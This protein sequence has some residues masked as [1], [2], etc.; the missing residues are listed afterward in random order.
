MRKRLQYILLALL[1]VLGVFP[2]NASGTAAD[3]VD[4]DAYV[5]ELTRLVQDT[6]SDYFLS[7]IEFRLDNTTMTVNGGV[8]EIDPGRDAAPYINEEGEPMLP[9]RAVSEALGLDVSFD[10]ATTDVN[11]SG[12]GIEI[13]LRSGDRTMRVNGRRVHMSS[14]PASRNG[15]TYLPARAVSESLL[16]DVDFIPEGKRVVLTKP[17]QTGRLIV[18]TNGASP[19][20]AY[21][22]DG[23]TTTLR[24]PDNTFIM[25]FETELDAKDA[26][27]KL[28]SVSVFAEPDVIVGIDAAYRSWGVAYI[29]A[30]KYLEYLTPVSKP[31]ITVAVLDT[32]VDSSHPFLAGRLTNGWNFINGSGNP[33]DGNGHGTHVAGTVAEL[34]L[35]NVTIIPVKVLSDQG[36]GSTSLVD[37]GIRYAADR[38]AAVINMSLGGA[39]TSQST[40]NAVQY[41]NGRNAVVVASAGNDGANAAGYTPANIPEVITVTA[42][43]SR[44]GRAYF[45]NFGNVIDVA[46]PG[47]SIISSIPGGR[48][49]AYDGTS[50]AAPHVSG[51]VALLK[52]DPRYADFNPSA[53]KTVLHGLTDD[54]GAPGFDIYFGHGIINMAKAVSSEPPA[55]PKDAEAP[56]VTVQPQGAAVTRGSAYN[57]SVTA[58][59]P[60]GGSLSYQWYRASGFGWSLIANAASPVY[61][62]PTNTLGTNSY[63][64]LVTNT[65]HNATGV[66]T[67]QT[68]SGAAA[69]TVQSAPAQPSPT[70][71]PQ[72]TPQPTPTPT[73]PQQPSPSPQ[74]PSPSPSPRPPSIGSYMLTVTIVN[75][76]KVTVTS[77]SGSSSSSSSSINSGSSVSTISIGG[78]AGSQIAMTAVPNSGYRFKGWEVVSGGLNLS[79]PS[80]SSVSFVMPSRNVEIRAVFE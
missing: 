47:V 48:Y 53:I 78:P 12:D 72:P 51:S 68:A 2:G 7:E 69:V 34:T 28:E 13:S 33:A 63:Y 21:E 30:D 74:P 6:W 20:A 39:G 18:Q 77:A 38:G 61:S 73:P 57:L 9:L 3:A 1:L 45:S 27:D 29:G 8:M 80:A 42:S 52:S 31:R 64:V 75:G 62:V 36:L 19:G 67:A 11:I 66:K 17:F 26:L 40:R 5:R 22:L 44:G 79:S 54:A 35:G 50:M 23:L 76:G 71:A 70:S 59:S 56:V 24:G 15:R 10:A 60:D 41:A 58:V 14:A 25:Q 43:D 16:L 32:G 49:A 46:A 65:N 55:L 4:I 37:A